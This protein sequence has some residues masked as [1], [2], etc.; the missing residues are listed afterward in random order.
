MDKNG[1]FFETEKKLPDWKLALLE[2]YP[3]HCC[4]VQWH[5]YAAKTSN[6]TGTNVSPIFIDKAPAACRQNIKSSSVTH[7]RKKKA[8]H[9]LL[10]SAIVTMPKK[11]V[12]SSVTIYPKRCKIDEYRKS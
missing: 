4:N 10:Q 2:E 1:F 3:S 6:C 11:N 12:C 9:H 8:F 7:L 5:P